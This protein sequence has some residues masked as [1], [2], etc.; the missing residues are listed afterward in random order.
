MAN[1][2]DQ[3][4]SGSEFEASGSAEHEFDVQTPD[5]EVLAT[6][7]VEDTMSGSSPDTAPAESPTVQANET[8]RQGS[9]E[10]N[11][12]GQD[13]P[14]GTNDPV[15]VSADGTLHEAAPESQR[16]VSPAPIPILS[17]PPADNDEPELTSTAPKPTTDE[18]SAE[19]LVVHTE[20]DDSG[21][22]SPGNQQTEDEAERTA[23]L[24]VQALPILDLANSE[25]ESLVAQEQSHKT[26]GKQQKAAS[27]KKR[28]GPALVWTAVGV[29]VL[30]GAYAGGQW[31]VSDNVARGTTVA[32][33]EI[34]GLQTD[35]AVTKLEE[36]L[37]GVLS[38]PIELA[39]SELT[40]T[41]V[42]QDAG[43][44]F[45]AKATIAGLTDFSMD[46]L[47]LWTHITGGQAID[48]VLNIDQSKLD[49]EFSAAAS[50]LVTQPVDGTVGFEGTTPVMTDAVEGSEVTVVAAK[51]LL[52]GELFTKQR[53]LVLPT[54]PIEPEI[55][56][57]ET[58]AAFAQAELLA[59]GP[60]T[61]AA[62]DQ[63]AEIPV[64]VFLPVSNFHPE[65]GKLELV[66][67]GE[68]ITKAVIDRTEN[69]LVSA[70]NASF[71]FEAGK[72]VIVAGKAGTTLDPEALTAAFIT[73][74][75]GADRTAT[76]ELI[77]KDPERGVAELEAMG[78]KEQVATFSTP[79]TGERL[80]NL[81]LKN[82]A[83]K[84]TG[85]LI[86]PGNEFDLLKV[87]GPVTAANG[88]HQAGV[89]VNGVHT[90]GMGGGLSQVA[91]TTYNTGFFAGMADVTH[92]PHSYYIGRYP[93]GREATVYEGSID[94]I[95]R[96]DSPHGVLMR[97]YVADGKFTVEAW[98]TKTY[99]VKH[100]SSGRY[101]VVPARTV[102]STDPKCKPFRGGNAGFGISIYRTV[103]EIATNKVII[104]EKNSWTYK[105][106]HGVT[107]NKPEPK[108][109][110]ED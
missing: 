19:P 77:E 109:D 11:S 50:S 86:E 12:L 93:E 107:C 79:I 18:P 99:E 82:A 31:L 4:P 1:S 28:G 48:P 17:T 101:N 8:E 46:P 41:I 108:T 94:M 110:S 98:S 96:N 53:P 57:Q 2:N 35:A 24:P 102:N 40:T 42:P 23:I 85:T 55:N 14:A 15:T 45:D 66:M 56:A 33:V 43:V 63:K 67:D 88:Y 36:T 104:D 89:I 58:A 38:T 80:R 54:Q 44:T 5:F 6:V 83:E 34:G 39:A 65:H 9:Q 74:A 60:V 70:Q 106:D 47:V 37:G 21:Q 62:G 7:P 81:N 71:K 51:D 20:T 16:T 61:V 22:E 97:S 59:S 30:A 32:G 103:T 78:V 27:S 64:E 90:D 3:V 69:L 25:Q 95:W 49:A 68:T 76:A 26:T 73:A 75:L 10:P 92:R 84:I 100:S 72:P 29:L 52:L 13:S 91:T 105:P 87:V